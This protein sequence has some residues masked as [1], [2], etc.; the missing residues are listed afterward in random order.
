MKALP[1]FAGCL[2]LFVAADLTLGA[3]MLGGFSISIPNTF[4]TGT[5]AVAAEVNQNFSAIATAVEARALDVDSRLDGLDAQVSSANVIRVSV[6]GSGFTSVASALISIND[7]SASNRYLVDVG[8]GVFDETQ[9]CS[10]PP[11][12]TLRGAGPQA[13]IIRS[14]RT[15][16]SAGNTSATV[17]IANRSALQDVRVENV[18]TSQ[19]AT[20]ISGTDLT[21][22]T[23]IFNVIA[24]VEG[25]GGSEHIALAVVEADLTIESSTL[26]ASGATGM[27]VAFRC[28]DSSGPFSQPQVLNSTLEGDG[29]SN[30]VGADLQATAMYMDGTTV[31]GDSVAVDAKVSGS[32]RIV[33]SR[34]ETLGLNPAYSATGSAAIL[35]G[36]NQFVAGN[37]SGLASQFKY[38]SCAKSNFDPVV[39]GTGSNI[40]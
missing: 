34:V 16:S 29:I 3:R 24:A 12:V 30:G 2:A 27:N 23:R 28:F 35:S 37:A 4:T 22:E 33:N 21:D 40:E 15:S 13:T 10:V 1:V 20:A 14:S 17:N 38:V 19:V 36:F 8:P 11:F 25:A 31:I 18:G 7:A 6:T 9:L 5:P 26:V 32:T 39:N